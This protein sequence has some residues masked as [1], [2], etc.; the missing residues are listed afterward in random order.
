MAAVI[1][2]EEERGRAPMPIFLNLSKI[3]I[4][5]DTIRFVLPGVSTKNGLEEP[6]CVIC[7]IDSSPPHSFF[8]KDAEEVLAFI[9]QHAPHRIQD[10]QVPA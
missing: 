8:G 2:K 7:F 3:S 1:I 10:V 6:M 5:V 9:K 4:N